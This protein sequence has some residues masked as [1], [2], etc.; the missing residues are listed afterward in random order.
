MVRTTTIIKT[1]PIVAISTGN[2]SF[3]CL[4]RPY[5]YNLPGKYAFIANDIAAVITWPIII[6]LTP[7][8]IVITRAR[9]VIGN[10]LKSTF[11]NK[12]DR[13]TAFKTFMFIA[14]MGRKT[15]ANII[16]CN[17]GTKAIHFSVS[18]KT[19]IGFANKAMNVIKGIFKKAAIFI[20]LPN[21]ETNRC[22]SV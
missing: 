3:N 17:M 19:T 8:G 1:I 5:P 2:I 13:P 7:S 6:A 14:L 11:K 22:L 20:I 9:S 15:R 16:H 18:N 10:L 21:M 4:A 12:S